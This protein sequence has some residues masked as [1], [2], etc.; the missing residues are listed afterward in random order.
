MHRFTCRR[1]DSCPVC[2]DGKVYL[3]CRD[4][5]VGTC[6]IQHERRGIRQWYQ[7]VRD[8][9]DDAR[10]PCRRW[11]IRAG[12]VWPDCADATTPLVNAWIRG[13]VAAVTADPF[14]IGAVDCQ[15]GCVETRFSWG[16]LMIVVVNEQQVGVDEQATIAALLDSAGLR[17]RGIAGVELGATTIGLGHQD[18]ASCVSQC[19]RVATA[20]QGG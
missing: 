20:V 16:P 15:A 9:L 4:G 18:L 2:V 7:E 8:L 5:V 17:G 3:N 11:V 12:P 14:P 19:D 1:S 10:V 13:L 6:P